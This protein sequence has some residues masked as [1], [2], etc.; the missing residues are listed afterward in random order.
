MTAFRIPL[1]AVALAL[2]APVL[3][4]AA[5]A[6]DAAIPISDTAEASQHA[7]L[8]DVLTER[9]RSDA[10][11]ET[12][13]KSFRDMVSSDLAGSLD[14]ETEKAFLAEISEAV[15]PVFHRVMVR[16]ES[17]LRPRAIEL[18]RSEMT[19]AEAKSVADLYASPQGQR[20]LD[21]IA[22][23]YTP[24]S[25]LS[26]AT[27]SGQIGAE[28]LAEDGQRA[29]DAAMGELDEQEM[30]EISL[31]VMRA[32]GFPKFNRLLPRYMALRVEVENSAMTAKEEEAMM[33]AMMPI[34]EKY[35]F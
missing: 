18:F 24:D 29:A 22:A 27:A 19:D 12:Y 9:N 5:L 3:P 25:A 23:N 20:M 2:V 8:Y 10:M 17:L 32:E 15:R 14:A 28:A 16:G 26:D 33:D 34:M 1:A 7:R 21:L 30:R 13:L 31:A 11:M 6:Q 4:T 35:L